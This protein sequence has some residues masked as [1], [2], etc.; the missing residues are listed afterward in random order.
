MSPLKNEFSTLCDSVFG[1]ALLQVLDVTRV[2]FVELADCDGFQD[3]I[4]QSV[5]GYTVDFGNRADTDVLVVAHRE[6]NPPILNQDLHLD[7]LCSVL[8]IIVVRFVAVFQLPSNRP[9]GQ[10][11]FTSVALGLSL[12][13]L[14]PTTSLTTYL[15]HCDLLKNYPPRSPIRDSGSVSLYM[16]SVIF[17]CGVTPILFATT[18]VYLTGSLP[19]SFG[20]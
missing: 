9:V 5:L 1:N 4:N 11:Y 16:M 8:L 17:V 12:V 6:V 3:H 13:L 20:A 2:Q 18:F 15:R 7:L 14:F 10:T 19:S